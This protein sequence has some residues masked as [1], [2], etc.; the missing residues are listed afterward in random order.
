M[1]MI[2]KIAIVGIIVVLLL[3]LLP[4]GTPIPPT[5]DNFGVDDARG[6]KNTNVLVPV[7][8]VNVQN[9]S[10]NAIIFN[11]SY[12]KSV[13]DIV[14]VQK[15]DL[16]SDWTLTYNN[17][18]GWGT[19]VSITYNENTILTGS[20]GSIV[21]LDFY[22]KGNGGDKSNIEF[23]DIQLSS[24]DYELGTAPAKNSVFTVYPIITY[25]NGWKEVRYADGRMQH[26]DGVKTY[27]RWGGEY[28]PWNE[29]NINNGNYPYLLEG[30]DVTKDG[31][32]IHLPT[33]KWLSWEHNLEGDQAK[34]KPV[35]TFS[36]IGF[37][38]NNSKSFPHPELGSG[39]Y[40][41]LPWSASQVADF[42]SETE[43]V[44]GPW[45]WGSNLIIYDSSETRNY[46][47]P[48][49][50]TVKIVG[51]EIRLL[52]EN[53]NSWFQSATYPVICK[54]S[55]W[56]VGSGGD[57][58]SGNVAHDNTTE[59]QATGKVELQDAVPDYVS[60]WRFDEG[61]GNTAHDENETN[62]ND[63][64]FTAG[65]TG[66]WTSGAK[67]GD[68]A[69]DFDGT[70]DYVD[71][72]NQFAPT[73]NVTYS[74]WIKLNA[75]N[76][77]YRWL[78]QSGNDAGDFIFRLADT[79]GH[80]RF[81]RWTGSGI[82][83]DYW[84]TSTIAVSAGNWHHVVAAYDGS[85]TDLYVD[86]QKETGSKTSNDA[87]VSAENLF[88]GKFS[89]NYFNGTIDEV[90]I[91]NRTLSNDEINQTMNNSHY[92]EGN[93]T[94]IV[95]DANSGYKWQNISFN[96][97][98]P[99]NTNVSI[100]AN[101]SDDNSS[102][103]GWQLV[104]S[105]ANSNQQYSIPS[106][107][108]KRYGKWRLKLQGNVTATPEVQNVTI[109][110]ASAAANPTLEIGN[111][112]NIENDWGQSSN[113]NISITVSGATAN[114]T[115]VTYN[116]TRL[117]NK[118]DWGNLAVGTHWHNQTIQHGTTVDDV[119]VEVQ[120][121]T[122]SSGGTN[123]TEYFWLNTTKR[124]NTATMD[125]N[126]T[127]S[128]NTNE[129]FYINA[130]CN[131]EYGDTFYGSADL[132]EDGIIIST[133]SSITD[134]VNFTWNESSDGVY[135]YSVRFYNLSYYNNVT[136]TY[137]NVTVSQPNYIPPDP[138]NLANTTYN[139]GVNFTFSPGSGNVTDGYNISWSNDTASGW[140]NTTNTFF[141]HT[142]SAHEWL[143]VSIW[144]YNSTGDGTLS[145]NSISDNVQIPNNAITLSVTQ[146]YTKLEGETVFISDTSSSD[147]DSDTPTYSCNR[148][149][150]FTD[151][152]T[153][154]GYG[155]W[156]TGT[157]DAGIYYVDIGVS[158]GYGSTDNKTL[159]ITINEATPTAPSNIQN[160][161]SNF[162][163]NWSWTKGSNSDFTDV[164]IND[165]WVE[166][167]TDAVYNGS[168]STHAT[169]KISL[170]E[171]NST[172]GE[173]SA[174]VNQTTTIPNNAPSLSGLPDNTTDEDTN[175]TDI[176]D[177]DD[178]FS[179]ADGDTPTYQVESNNQSANVSV[180]INGTTN[181]VSYTL[182][183]NWYGVASVIVNVTDGYGGEDNDTFLITINSVN[184]APTTSNLQTEG[185]I[186]PTAITDYTP[187]FTWSYS[188]PV[189]G[190]TQSHW[191]IYVG[192][193]EGASD[194]WNSSELAGSDT[195]DVYAGSALSGSTT[196]YVQVR[197]KDGSD[198]S[199]WATGTFKL[200][201]LYTA[202]PT[203]LA[204][205]TGNFWI[206]HTWNVGTGDYLITD[207]Y[208]VSVNGTW[209]NSSA[210]T[211]KNT[212]LSAHAWANISIYA[213][214]NSFANIS[215]SSV[216]QNTQVPNNAISITNTSD[217]SG[218]EGEQVYFDFDFTDADNDT[219]TFATNATSGSLNTSTGVFNWTTGSGDAGT[220]YW[221]FNVSDGYG[222]TS[223]YVA[224]IAVSGET[225]N[226]SGYVLDTNNVGIENAH[227]TNNINS[228]NDYTDSSGYY[229]LSGLENRS[230]TI[231]ASKTGYKDNSITATIS[232]SNLTDQNII[233]QKSGR[234]YLP[235]L[236]TAPQ[237]PKIQQ[238]RVEADTK[239]I[240]DTIEKYWFPVIIFI[241]LFDSI[242][243]TYYMKK[244]QNNKGRRR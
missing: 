84:D 177:L 202:T 139:F 118:T 222:S 130:T 65:S 63:G 185:Q 74:A 167:S 69:I 200:L 197:T 236:V 136:S 229:K 73:S 161:T 207:S 193:S 116:D 33:R 13:I 173:Y 171:Y 151:F 19:R 112:I 216:S 25:G 78:S 147:L 135:N 232:G 96:D 228:V 242:A 70:D 129:D 108:Q 48:E 221:L 51:G 214:N 99:T 175:Q 184:D 88:I 238:W 120:A 179:D 24:I 227:V 109:Y 95:K 128:A 164:L 57:A 87:T 98:I 146:S 234:G 239:K 153:T 30:N 145:A 12:D 144:A 21:V 10:I 111:N 32:T 68:Y 27:R 125:S 17:D 91:Y 71:C 157:N 6:Y 7:N 148:T 198:W 113:S 154:T 77:N 101:T 174:F 56:T 150:L 215:S 240:A 90:R 133:Q 237:L 141:N 205:T 219:G 199:S 52:Y 2:K 42:V 217:W 39:R 8:I 209:T 160:S 104:Q 9:E 235:S 110:S 15:G 85:G 46:L 131:E 94:S 196:Y 187:D 1:A 62:N 16:T 102:F 37:L 107:Y 170:R 149:D 162:W 55:S 231:T 121:T 134:Y 122:T 11:V 152:D 3:S 168:Y 126:T 58:W 180:T 201:Y 163:I 82:N 80:L 34:V 67:Y 4:V 123:D 220:Y 114:E 92:S 40:I 93:L 244:I 195:S 243:I 226:I 172:L 106:A 35:F 204:N 45:H 191:E 203:N 190:D 143:N 89:T 159:T 36:D 233:L 137:S 41:A 103:S 212:S 83:F 66:N 183:A 178:Y 165:S 115:N 230:Y 127:Q 176:F 38:I 81:L 224:T 47:S 23:S 192:T 194:M 142:T 213:W 29:L 54:F 64:S 22:V 72:G 241:I 186:N 158:D 97:T 166:N 31:V 26:T 117:I 156:T 100:Y 138:V 105:N 225:Y 119:Y 5:A 140:D 20:T 155:N 189:E 59:V 188:D 182:A 18:F 124:T 181:T 61:S 43:I 49:N 75:L 208:N 223:S 132:L 211:Y 50:Y 60:K 28:R 218:D 86:G 14:N 44:I 53:N 210:N 76:T 206:N 169:K 79:S